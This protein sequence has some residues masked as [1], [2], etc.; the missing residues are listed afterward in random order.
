MAAI[1]NNLSEELFKKE[2]TLS[3]FLNNNDCYEQLIDSFHHKLKV[4]EQFSDEATFVAEE[5]KRIQ[6]IYLNPIEIRA[7]NGTILHE[8]NYT[9]FVKNAYDWLSTG[10]DWSIKQIINAAKAQRDKQYIFEP[11][12]SNSVIH[13]LKKG[14]GYLLYEKFLKEKQKPNGISETTEK[15]ILEKV[16]SEKKVAME[17]ENEPVFVSYCWDSKEHE[18]RVLSFTNFIRVKGFKAEMDKM[19]S[20][21]ETA[22]DFMKMMHQKMVNSA[23]VIIVLSKGYKEKA[24][25][26]KGGVGEE[27]ALVI[28]DIKS[29]PNK[30]ILV[31]FDG[32]ADAI[33]PLGLSGREIVNMQKED[34]KELL[35]AKLLGHKFY[36]FSEVADQKPVLSKKIY[37]ISI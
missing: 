37:Q 24:E 32:I 28:K 5:I 31:S 34:S 12:F 30:Y 26:F 16:S 15:A 1:N 35:F 10:Q 2:A 6:T 8:N 29:Q 23:K 13:H 17:K 27:Y 14:V 22:I 18:E 3:F 9:K 25:K 20:Q 36:N 4:I 19:L 11:E 21:E 33:V 7:L